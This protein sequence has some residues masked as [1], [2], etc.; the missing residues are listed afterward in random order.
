MSAKVLLTV[1]RFAVLVQA[2]PCKAAEGLLPGLH[3]D[4]CC[5]IALSRRKSGTELTR[6]NSPDGVHSACCGCSSSC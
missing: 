6:E 5:C 3:G 2:A 1:A 4:S